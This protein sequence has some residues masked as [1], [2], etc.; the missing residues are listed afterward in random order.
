M[1][2]EL[3]FSNFDDAIKELEKLNS[4]KVKT[5]GRWSFYQIMNHCA[6]YIEYSMKGFPYSNLFLFFFRIVWGRVKLKKIL[7]QG[8]IETGQTNPF[9]PR[10]REDGDEQKAMQR[11]KN[12]IDEFL[13]YQGEFAVHPE[14]NKMDRSEWELFHAYYLANH[15]SFVHIVDSDEPVVDPERS[16]KVE[17]IKEELLKNMS[18]RMGQ[19]EED[20]EDVNPIVEEEKPETTQTAEAPKVEEEQESTEEAT[21]ETVDEDKE[22][23]KPVS[24]EDKM[25]DATEPVLAVAETPKEQKPIAKKKAV[26]KKKAVGKKKAVS[27]KKTATKKKAASKKKAVGKKKAVS[28]KKIATKKKAASKKK[29]VGKKKAVSKKKTATKKKAVTKKKVAN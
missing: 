8:Y 11:L 15:L 9:A 26:T 3:R 24:A 16:E 27:K 23:S 29:A 1:N 14:F 20:Q 17:Q 28:K 22:E 10:L 7:A 4:S 19:K 12:A 13:E 18:T 25:P 5:T 2:R 21:E 6:E